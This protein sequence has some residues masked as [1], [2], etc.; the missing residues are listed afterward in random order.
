MQ[1]FDGRALRAIDLEHPID[2][3]E[4][5]FERAWTRTAPTRLVVGDVEESDP[6]DRQAAPARGVD[7][8]EMR[9]LAVEAAGVGARDE[10]RGRAHCG[11]GIPRSR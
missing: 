11:T 2:H 1:L 3:G 9:V 8:G 4:R 7:M 5:G 6:I 10:E